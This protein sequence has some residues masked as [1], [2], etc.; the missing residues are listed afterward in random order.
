VDTGVRVAVRE[1]V[2]QE[3]GQ[4]RELLG[5]VVGALVEPVGAA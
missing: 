3:A 4:L 5:E 1:V 2:V